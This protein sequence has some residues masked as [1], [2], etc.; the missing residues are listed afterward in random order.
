MAVTPQ[1]ASSTIVRRNGRFLLVKRAHPPA[2]A[3]YAFPGGRTEQGE[4][5]E[6]TAI[7]E[8]EEETGLVAQN[9][10]PF[11]VYDLIDRDSSG[12]VTS[13]FRLSVFLADA[14]PSAIA[15]AADDAAELGWYTAQEIHS[16]PVPVSVLECV[17]RIAANSC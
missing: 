9:V 2:E 1:P 5:A 11:A 7:R 8:L 14:D 13:F 16:L 12:T 10:R 4:T 17:D 6:E 3:M 15:I